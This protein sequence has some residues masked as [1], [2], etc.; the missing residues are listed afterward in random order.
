MAILRRENVKDHYGNRVN[1]RTLENTYI[2]TLEDGLAWRC[3]SL[4]KITKK[5][6]SLSKFHF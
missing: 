4:L 5:V 2:N 3:S 6:T 1:E